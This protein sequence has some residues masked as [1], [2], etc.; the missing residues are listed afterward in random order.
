MSA[1]TCAREVDAMFAAIRRYKLN[2]GAHPEF[3]RVANQDFMP[4][5]SAMPGFVAYYGIDSTSDEWASLSIFESREA[6][7]EGNRRA[8]D[9][10][11]ERLRPLVASGPEIL[12]G[13]LVV[14]KRA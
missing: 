4:I 2:A 9:F 6:A 8:A 12:L 10:V 1:G 11:R 5:L 7:E 13:T 14:S 3:D